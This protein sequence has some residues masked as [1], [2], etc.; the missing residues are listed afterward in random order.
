MHREQGWLE[1]EGFVPINVR[2]TDRTGYRL[3][4]YLEAVAVTPTSGKDHEALVVTRVRPSTIHA[5]LLALGLTPGRPGSIAWDGQAA[6]RE[7]AEGPAVRVL[8]RAADQPPPGRPI[9]WFIVG[10]DQATAF[11][12]QA[13]GDRPRW[14]FAGSLVED[15]RYA[16]DALGLVVGLHTFGGEVVALRQPISPD[17]FIDRPQ[18]IAHPQR[19]PPF[20]TSVIVRIESASERPEPAPEPADQ[21]TPDAGQRPS[22]GSRPGG[23]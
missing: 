12:A 19:T 1:I 22:E 5:A 23:G 6:R 20:G 2:E 14:V 15:G 10:D 21:A 11:D 4:R 8:L 7:P 16:A 17:S 18:W 13:L 3:V 9:E